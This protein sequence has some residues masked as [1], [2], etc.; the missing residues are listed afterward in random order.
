[1][2][3]FKVAAIL[4]TTSSLARGFVS[5]RSHVGSSRSV[6]NNKS[7]VAASIDDSATEAQ[8]IAGAEE[9]IEAAAA[10]FS[11]L[12]E[13]QGEV[14]TSDAQASDSSSSSIDVVAT[15]NSLLRIAAST[16]RGQYA[17]SSQKEEASQLF[18]QL[19]S[20]YEA[21]FTEDADAISPALT[22][23]WSLLYSNTQLFRS[24][25]F[26]LAA[27]AVCKTDDEVKQFEWFCNMHRAALAISTIGAVNQVISKD[28]RMVNEFEVKAGAVPFLSDFTPFR[29]SGGLPVTFDG[30][31]V[32]SADITQNNGEWEIYMDTVEIKGSNI[33]GLRSILDMENSKL[34]SR[35]LS[36]I[37]EVNV[38]SYEVPRPVLRTTFVDDGMRIVRDEDGNVFVYG[39]TSDSQE[40]KDYSDVLPD[41][42][43]AGLLE[44]FNDAVTKFYL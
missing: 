33:P 43:V 35:D 5:S 42:G 14:K 34:K 38:N 4:L 41:L 26:F 1:M 31:I 10:E 23:T 20:S 2:T 36:K 6:H 28:G 13:E 9:A 15:Q 11:A 37:L 16:D 7:I 24:S 17:S 8:V 3:S 30:A 19:E 18:S 39:K 25:P 27:R 44:G 22:G 12:A 40:P 29:Y 21:T 32:S